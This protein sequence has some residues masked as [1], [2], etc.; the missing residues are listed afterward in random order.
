MSK[1][2]DEAFVQLW[3]KSAS[4][5]EVAAAAGSTARQVVL[6][7]SHMRRAGVPLKRFRASSTKLDVK[8]LAELVRA[9][10]EIKPSRRPP[11]VNRTRRPR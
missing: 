11:A 2:P 10:S 6:R 3:Q 9:E 7:A 1:V 4:P 5:A 8:K